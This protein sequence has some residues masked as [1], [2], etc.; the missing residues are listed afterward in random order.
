MQG[1]LDADHKMNTSLRWICW[2]RFRPCG[3]WAWL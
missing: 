3:K 2:R 1:N